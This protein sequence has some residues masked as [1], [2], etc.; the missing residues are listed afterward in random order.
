[1]EN[2]RNASFYCL[3]SKGE[4]GRE[5]MSDEELLS[6]FIEGR[7]EGAFEVARITGTQ[8]AFWP[9]AGACLAGAEK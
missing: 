4:S 6:D 5:W 7:E 8:N 3:A 9:F 1:M 2:R